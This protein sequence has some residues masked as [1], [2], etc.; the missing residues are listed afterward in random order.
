MVL[1]KDTKEGQNVF[2]FNRDTAEYKI[3]TITSQPTMPHYAPSQPILMVDV[4]IKTD[5]VIKTYSIPENLSVTYAGDWC[6]ATEQ[7]DLL[8]EVETLDMKAEKA[9]SEVPKLQEIRE[10]CKK[11]KLDLNPQL[12]IQQATEERFGRIET[13]MEQLS[14]MFREF[15]NTQ[16]PSI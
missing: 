12:K 10:K 4:T 16:K 2:L 14:A 9:I 15:M 7:Q 13:N 1:F 5:D 8:R 6:I 11:L 3:G